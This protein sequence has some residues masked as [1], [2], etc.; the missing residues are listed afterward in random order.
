M[1]K[2]A[3]DPTL[4]GRTY[5][6]SP[7]KEVSSPPPGLQQAPSLRQSDIEDIDIEEMIVKAH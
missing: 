1:T 6:S 5:L 3:E 2:T 7:Y 4:S